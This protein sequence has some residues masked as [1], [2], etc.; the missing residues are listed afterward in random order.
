MAPPRWLHSELEWVESYQG[1]SL[2]HPGLQTPQIEIPK[3]K[4]DTSCETFAHVTRDYRKLAA[5]SSVAFAMSASF[6]ARIR[7][8]SALSS[9]S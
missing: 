7:A 4:Q 8:G 1:N 6:A 5:S 2:P 3:W 9:R